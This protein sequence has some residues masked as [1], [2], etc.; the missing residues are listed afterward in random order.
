MLKKLGEVSTFLARLGFTFKIII[1][2]GLNS[3]RF[4]V[5]V[6]C[7]KILFETCSLPWSLSIHFVK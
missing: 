3:S 4:D 7:D 6:I 5:T 1:D 2:F